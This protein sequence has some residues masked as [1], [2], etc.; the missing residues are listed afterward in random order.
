MRIVCQG[1]S[2][3]LITLSTGYRIVT[4]PFDA[5]TGYPVGKTKADAVLVSHHHHDHDAVETVEG[6]TK[7]V[8]TAGVHTLEKDI[9]VTAVPSFH[10]PEQGKLRGTNLIMVLEAEG[11]KVD[12]KSVV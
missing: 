11:L 7:V 4:D 8:D 1:H 2:K 12:R 3:F 10:D 9:Q 5:S 6:Y